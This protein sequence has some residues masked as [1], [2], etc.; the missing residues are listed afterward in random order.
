MEKKIG[1]TLMSNGWSDGKGRYITNFLINRPKGTVFLKSVDASEIIKNADN[2]FLLL[3]SVME[4]IGE[5][6]VVQV[7]INSASA[8]VKARDMLMAKRKKK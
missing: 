2:L 3:D 7:V 6:N 4:E 8:Y 5:N 1:C